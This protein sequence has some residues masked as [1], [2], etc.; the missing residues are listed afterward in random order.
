MIIPVAISLI[1]NK[2]KN[3]L[4]AGKSL[5]YLYRTG[6]DKDGITNIH[7]SCCNTHQCNVKVIFYFGNQKGV[8]LLVDAMLSGE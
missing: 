5:M 3:C 2:P 6:V 7:I 1:D 8:F 4:E